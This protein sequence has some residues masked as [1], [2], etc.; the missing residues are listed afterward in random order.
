MNTGLEDHIPED[1]LEGYAMGKVSALD[2][3]PLEEHLLIC[4]ACQTH[5]EET[6][7]YIRLVRSALLS[8]TANVRPTLVKTSPKP[9]AGLPI[10]QPIPA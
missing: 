3:A 9:K 2:R 1:L 5:L 7:E 6:A 8:Y 4:P 10:A